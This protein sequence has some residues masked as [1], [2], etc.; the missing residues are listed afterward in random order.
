MTVPV[1]ASRIANDFCAQIRDNPDSTEVAQA[2]DV[3]TSIIAAAAATET[4]GAAARAQVGVGML[5]AA[6]A[7]AFAL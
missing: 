6:A 3:A 5:G 4:P 7:V 1:D 2:S